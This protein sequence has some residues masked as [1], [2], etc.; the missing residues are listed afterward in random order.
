MTH[1]RA[2]RRWTSTAGDLLLGACCPGCG[3]AALG[4]CPSCSDRLSDR[5]PRTALPSPPPPGFPPT[6]TAGPYDELFRQLISAHKER[7]AW[8][9]TGALGRQLATAVQVLL[10]RTDPLPGSNRLVL[11]PIPSSARAIRSRGRDAT[12]AIAIS[13]ARWLR[14]SDSRPVSVV[15]R[16]RPGRRL[17]D[18]SGLSAQQRQANLAGAYRIRGGAPAWRAAAAGPTA[19]IVVDDLVTT[20]ASL[21][22]ARRA[23]D[24]AG[25]TVLGAA[26]VAATVR[27]TG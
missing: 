10:H 14:R 6:V 12:R 20:G 23:L 13:A 1:D 21:A 19:A 17:A 27:R 8:L 3:D 7:Q 16:L 22:E 9:L 25:V 4:L 2:W 24:E 5:S 11:V 18:Q 26:V 15:S